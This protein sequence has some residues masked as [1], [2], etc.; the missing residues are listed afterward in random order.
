MTNN[1]S[2]LNR[3]LEEH[4]DIV[5]RK[6][7]SRSEEL[8]LSDGE[9]NGITYLAAAINEYAPGTKLHCTTTVASKK[10]GF[11]D[12]F[13]PTTLL[14]AVLAFI[15]GSLGLWAFLSGEEL[16]G[17][18]AGFLDIAKICAGAVVGSASVMMASGVKQDK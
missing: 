11:F 9:D 1:D 6:I 8:A 5:R 10:K 7:V 14:S 13:T 16:E 2:T 15:F 18:G 12:Y 3:M 17:Q 4:L